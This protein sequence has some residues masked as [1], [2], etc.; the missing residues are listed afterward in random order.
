MP[1]H[2]LLLLCAW[3][4]THQFVCLPKS[5]P[6]SVCENFCI[7][8]KNFWNFSFVILLSKIQRFPIDFG[9][10]W[11]KKKKNTRSQTGI[12]GVQ[13]CYTKG[14]YSN[15]FHMNKSYAVSIFLIHIWLLDLCAYTQNTD[16]CFLYE[17]IK[18][19]YSWLLTHEHS[20]HDKQI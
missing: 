12:R 11:T 6:V 8:K 18:K 3:K 5:A 1:Q 16:T 9:S 7:T 14:F 13:L 20:T 15:I 10:L 19:I 4:Y 2:T 17:R